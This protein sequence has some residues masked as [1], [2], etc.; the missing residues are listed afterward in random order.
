MV[1]AWETNLDQIF[2][3]VKTCVTKGCITLRK[4]H[5]C[6][7]AQR[8]FQITTSRACRGA[9]NFVRG[10]EAG[11]ALTSLRGC[12][13][14]LA[15]LFVVSERAHASTTANPLKIIL[16]HHQIQ[17]TP[18]SARPLHSATAPRP[19]LAYSRRGSCLLQHS[20]YQMSARSPLK[21]KAW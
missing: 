6:D 7:V 11:S 2:H 15:F 14:V 4:L 18:K 9:S 1:T 13:E 8:Q 17:Y 21:H 16:Q 12:R 20:H 19:L 5:N 10:A 3:T